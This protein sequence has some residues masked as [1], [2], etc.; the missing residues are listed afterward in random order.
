M[1]QLVI[2]QQLFKNCNLLSLSGSAGKLIKPTVLQQLLK[3]ARCGGPAALYRRWLSGRLVC[4]SVFYIVTFWQCCRLSSCAVCSCVITF[5][6]PSNLE[7]RII[8]SATLLATNHFT[9]LILHPN[10][11]FATLALYQPLLHGIC[12]I[13]SVH[14]CTLTSASLFCIKLWD[15]RYCIIIMPLHITVSYSESEAYQNYIQL[16]WFSNDTGTTVVNLYIT[17]SYINFTSPEI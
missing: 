16:V 2:L 4:C 11:Q 15:K 14:L 13:G 7:C 6:D 3:Y 10:S 17:E 5:V 9:A 12:N 1:P 8:D